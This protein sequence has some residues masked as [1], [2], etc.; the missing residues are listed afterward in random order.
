MLAKARELGANEVLAAATSAVRD[1]GNPEALIV[2]AKVEMGLDIKVIN[3]EDEARLSR[4]VALRE[5][6]ALS[7]GAMPRDVVFFDVGGGST[8]L[9]W[10]HKGRVADSASLDLGVRRSSEI[11]G[12]RQPVSAEVAALLDAHINALL[13]EEAPLVIGSPPEDEAHPDAA[14]SRDAAR[15]AMLSEYPDQSIRLAGLGGTASYVVWVLQG[16]RGED[17]SDPHGKRV[18][19]AELDELRDYLAPL[20]LDEVKSTPNLDPARADI[21]YAGVCLLAALCRFY[22]ASEFVVVDRGLRFGLLLG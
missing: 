21:I 18:T 16:R 7:G 17:V 9:T 4:T 6:A 11:C 13:D 15:K 22:G 1:A 12:V 19:L 8:E 14:A 10:C 5:L 2:P 3:G 20:S